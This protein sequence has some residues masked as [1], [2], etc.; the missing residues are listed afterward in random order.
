[1]SDRVEVVE[2]E[3]PVPPVGQPAVGGEQLLAVVR[4]PRRLDLVIDQDGQGRVRN[5]AVVFEAMGLGLDPGSLRLTGRDQDQV[6][7]LDLTVSA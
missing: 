1:M 7:E 2:G 5:S 4:I 3:D 6:R